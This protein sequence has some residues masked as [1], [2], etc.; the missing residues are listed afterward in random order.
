[1]GEDASRVLSAFGLCEKSV[2]RQIRVSGAMGKPL[3]RG[4]CY[5]TAWLV[6]VRPGATPGEGDHNDGEGDLERKSNRGE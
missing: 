2:E 4:I 6:A 3:P 1:V 5:C